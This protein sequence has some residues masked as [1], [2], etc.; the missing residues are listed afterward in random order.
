M[1]KKILLCLLLL[2]SSQAQSQNLFKSIYKDFLK[3][4]TIY[5]AGEV[6]NSVEAPYP[7]YVVRTN[8]NGSLYDIPRV[9]DNTTKY[10][11]D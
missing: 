9:E 4:G 5:G 8:E 11:F 2:V 6:R 10:P 1:M 3:Y 7:T